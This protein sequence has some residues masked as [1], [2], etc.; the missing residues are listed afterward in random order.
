MK[1]N[2]FNNENLD[3]NSNKYKMSSIKTRKD[4]SE[5]IFHSGIKNKSNDSDKNFD[6]TTT[7][8]LNSDKIRKET[9]EIYEKTAYMN[10]N[11]LLATNKYEENKQ[12]FTQIEISCFSPELLLTVI[13]DCQKN[14]II[15]NSFYKK[16]STWAIV[17]YLTS[18]EATKSLKFFEAHSFYVSKGIKVKFTDIDI[19]L[20]YSKEDIKEENNIKIIGPVKSYY[21]SFLSML[22]SW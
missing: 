11:N 19:N 21:S 6:F 8:I 7:N 9:N 20:L 22:F 1:G 2:F 14:G 10:D 18:A 5:L 4:V 3:V 13:K 12:K 15:I 16:G 17:K